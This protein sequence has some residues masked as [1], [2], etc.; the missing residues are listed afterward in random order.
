MNGHDGE[1]LSMRS[2]DDP[3]PAVGQRRRRGVRVTS[4]AAIAL[5][6][7]IGGGAAA[8]ATT[9]STGS[10]PAASAGPTSGSQ[11]NRPPMGGSPP[12]AVGT[13][14]SVGDGTFTIT[15]SDGTAVTVNVDSTTTYRDTSVASATIANVT[16]GEHVAVFGSDTSN[17]V[18]ATSVGIGDPSAGGGGPGGKGGTPPKAPASSSS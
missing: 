16:V 2:G 9:S 18:T 15:A 14:T 3:F 6:L 5:G 8:G 4:A 10:T 7:A 11:A 12:A 1:S 17:V 13:V